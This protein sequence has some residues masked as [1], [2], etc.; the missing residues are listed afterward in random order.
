VF[1][2]L[3]ALILF[4]GAVI[5]LFPLL[6]GKSGWQPVALA[7]AF[8][9]PAAGLWLYDSYGTPDGINVKGVP[10]SA[11]TSADPH[12][13]QSG[14]MDDM[15]AGLQQR[16]EQNP[17]DLEGW[18]LLARTLRSTGKYAEAADAMEQAHALAPENPVVM[19]DLAEAWVYETPDG[20]V[21]ESSVAMLER[22]L[23]IDPRV[24]KGLWLMG[25]A[26]MQQGDDAFAISYWQSLL[27]QLEPG[28]NVHTMVA[29]QIDEAQAR[30]GMMPEAHTPPVGEAAAESAGSTPDGAA[31]ADG[32]WRGTRL[33]L[34]AAD[35]AKQALANG[36]VLYIM[37][38]TPGP[39]MGPPLGVRRL[40][41]PTFPLE[42]TL[43]DQDS[44]LQE[45]PIST[46]PEIQLQARVS[47]TGSPA[48]APGDWESASKD[49]EL[50]SASLVVLQVDQQ[51]E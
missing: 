16:L 20:Q 6:R 23:D 19:A 5:T 44:M 12:S 10:Q 45:R 43:T 39:A 8:I 42:V 13:M 40:T 4:I 47:L 36:A 7:L 41:N 33:V 28:S 49:V 22:A 9:V 17:A 2:T 35:G 21:P 3:A 27:E 51:V 29:N 26:S 46:S 34:D 30:M 24:Q 38:R 50:A 15:I 25:I 32:A 31:T 18:M 14:E 37:I 48:K 1:W 11:S